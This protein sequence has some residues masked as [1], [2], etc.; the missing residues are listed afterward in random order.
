M[1]G[2]NVSLKSGTRI[3]SRKTGNFSRL[4]LLLVIWQSSWVKFRMVRHYLSLQLALG[5]WF[6]Q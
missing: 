2:E 5:Y 3:F 6:V 4:H 1:N